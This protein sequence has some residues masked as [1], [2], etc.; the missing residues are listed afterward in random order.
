MQE[1]WAL[2][3]DLKSA[4]LKQRKQSVNRKK[5]GHGKKNRLIVMHSV[6]IDNNLVSLIIYFIIG[7]NQPTQLIIN[8]NQKNL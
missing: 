5:Q 7:N 2:L 3:K 4:M 1:N 6:T 8:Y